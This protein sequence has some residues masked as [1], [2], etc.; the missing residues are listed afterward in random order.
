MALRSN[1]DIDQV[2]LKLFV[3][4]VNSNHCRRGFLSILLFENCMSCSHQSWP[5]VPDVERNREHEAA[6]VVVVIL[7]CSFVPHLICS[8][9]IQVAKMRFRP[10]ESATGCDKGKLDTKVFEHVLPATTYLVQHY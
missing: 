3:I 5:G 2:V 10:G 8:L 1:C 4:N 7:N 6:W 9:V